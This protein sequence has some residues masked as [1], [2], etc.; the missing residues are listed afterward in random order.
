MRHHYPH[1][2]QASMEYTAQQEEAKHQREQREIQA[3]WDE[4]WSEKNAGR[5]EKEQSVK[6]KKENKK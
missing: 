4:Y 6:N 5:K 1:L 3:A 2:L